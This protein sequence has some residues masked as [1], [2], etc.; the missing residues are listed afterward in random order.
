MLI[1]SRDISSATGSSTIIIQCFMHLLQNMLVTTHSQVVIGA[2]YDDFVLF[3]GHMSSRKLL[4][5]AID[6]V[7][8]AVRLVLVLL[9]KF[10]LVE[11]LIIEFGWRWRIWRSGSDR[12]GLFRI[13][14]SGSIN[15]RNVCCRVKSQ[16][17]K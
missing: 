17:L 4:S 6:V 5:Q 11:S 1:V 15:L 10:R 13:R 16:F 12:I 9:I 7:K 2:P 3:V 8:V 14:K